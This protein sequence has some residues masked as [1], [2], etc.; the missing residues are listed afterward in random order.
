MNTEDVK[1][2][3]AAR[4]RQASECIDDGKFLLAANRGARTVINRAYYGAFYAVLALL[5]TIGKV[6]RKHS[7]ALSLFD[8]EF[9]KPG[10]LA[11]DLSAE[12]HRLFDIRQEDDYQ[13]IDPIPQAEAEEAIHT[14]E[15]FVQE[16]QRYLI[17]QDYLDV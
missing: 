14:A 4:I 8:V 3:V 16:I 17:A 6:P 7:G 13:I 2:L 15:N 12:L 5:Q 9:V 10:L 1:I 11:K